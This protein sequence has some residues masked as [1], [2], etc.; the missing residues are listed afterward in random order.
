MT[1]ERKHPEGEL[2]RLADGSLPADRQ[3]GL[4]AQIRQSPELTAALAEQQRAVTILRALDEPAPAGLRARVDELTG[5]AAPR[6]APSRRA[7]RWRR[8]FVLP[9]ATAIAA[10][11]AAVVILVSGGGTAPTVPVAARLALASATLPAPPVNPD[12]AQN[13]TL[14]AAGIPFPAWG[15]QKGWTASGAR[16]D[17]VGG[18]KITTVFYLGRTGSRIGYAITDGA[19]LSGVHGE[20]V[21][22]YGVRFTLQQSGPA[23]VISWVR[24]GHTC[25]IAGRSVSFAVLLKLATE[26]E[27]QEGVSSQADVDSATYL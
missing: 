15:P 7:P 12:E 1:D 22:R 24:M 27:R 19:P 10:A 14:S 11:V 6:R 20:T 21:S 26:D 17:S 4:L 5:R 16:T 3:A 25:V 2:T 18:R 23:R 9:G 13:L 8:A